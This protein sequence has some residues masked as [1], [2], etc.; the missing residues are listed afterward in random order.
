MHSLCFL[1]LT[2]CTILS[3]CICR[4]N[5][6]KKVQNC[7]M[8]CNQSDY[9]ILS[10]NRLVTNTVDGFLV[11][12]ELIGKKAILKMTVTQ[13]DR[14]KKNYAVKVD[15]SKWYFD[16][17]FA[18]VNQRPAV[19][20]DDSNSNFVIIKYKSFHEISAPLIDNDNTE[21]FI[22]SLRFGALKN[23]VNYLKSNFSTRIEKLE[24]QK[25]L[26]SAFSKSTYIGTSCQTPN[27]IRYPSASKHCASY[28]GRWFY[29]DMHDTFT[30]NYLSF[31]IADNTDFVYTY[32]L[33][34][35]SD[36]QN[37]RSLANLKVGT[38][39]DVQVFNIQEPIPIRY[40]KMEGRNNKDAY[41]RFMYL[42]VDLI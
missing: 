24:M 21:E 41:L 36:K 1:L 39:H 17:L 28:S 33:A 5:A 40:I 37:W 29:I 22:S 23:E 16:E 8:P 35:S 18:L 11:Q 13:S 9:S 27:P 15:V 32:N 14:T 38:P 25:K 4:D 31:R 26:K 6:G 20:L 12:T 19:S 42:T 10:I 30:I 34:V 2:F 7:R 3:T